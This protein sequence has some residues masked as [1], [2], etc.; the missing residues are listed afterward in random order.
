MTYIIQFLHSLT[1]CL[2]DFRGIMLLKLDELFEPGFLVRAMY[3]PNRVMRTDVHR[4]SHTGRSRLA[5]LA[6]ADVFPMR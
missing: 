6:L 2:S 4:L 3:T 1:K 5:R